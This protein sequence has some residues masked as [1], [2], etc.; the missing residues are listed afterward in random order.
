MK[1]SFKLNPDN[2]ILSKCLIFLTLSPF[3]LVGTVSII[4]G[5]TLTILSVILALPLLGLFYYLGWI[6]EQGEE[7]EI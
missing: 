6:I 2:N 4:L 1:K 5:V 7:E 3:M